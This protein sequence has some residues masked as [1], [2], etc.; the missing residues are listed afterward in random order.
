MPC[1]NALPANSSYGKLV[2]SDNRLIS[3]CA[4]VCD[5]GFRQEGDHC[6]ACDQATLP[7]HAEYVQLTMRQAEQYE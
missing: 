1:S 3:S 4:F 7:A 2:A 6:V 5:A